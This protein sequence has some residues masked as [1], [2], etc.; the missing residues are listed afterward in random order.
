M[1]NARN[2]AFIGFNPLSKSSG[3]VSGKEEDA[4]YRFISPLQITCG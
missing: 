1:T 2:K 3:I 4:R